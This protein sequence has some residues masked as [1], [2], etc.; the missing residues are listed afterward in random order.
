M[1]GHPDVDVPSLKVAEL[2]EELT[3]RG[4]ETKGLKKDLA[5]RLQA[6]QE[7]QHADKSTSQTETILPESTGNGYVI[8]QEAVK[9]NEGVGRTMVDGYPE[10]TSTKHHASLPTEEIKDQ[11]NTEPAALDEEVAKVVAQEESKDVL[12]PTPSPPK[13]LSPL[14]KTED[15]VGKVMVD[16]Y[17]ENELSKHHQTPSAGKDVINTEP[18]ALDKDLAKF[19]AEE[20]SKDVLTPT[21]SPPKR[22]SPLPVSE[23]EEDMQIIENEEDLIKNGESS[24]KR[25]RSRSITPS[26]SNKVKRIKFDLPERLSHIKEIPSSVLYINNLKRPLLHSTLYEYLKPCSK[27]KIDIPKNSKMPFVS[28]EYKG[29]W[30]SGVKSHAYVTYSSIEESI[31]IAEKIENKKWPEDTGDRLKIHFI[32]ENQLHELIEKEEKA[33]ENGRQKL[34]LKVYKSEEND[35]DDDN[36]QEWIYELISSGGL[37][38]ILPPPSSSSSK[39]GLPIIGR[40]IPSGPRAIPLTG[41]NSIQPSRNSHDIPLRGQGVGIRGR[42]NL[43]PN[44]QRGDRRYDKEIMKNGTGEGLRGWSDERDK[45]RKQKEVLRMRPTKYRPRLF[46]KKGP[47]AI[48]GS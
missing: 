9:D 24:K 30:L 28:S 36:N 7:S 13:S 40:E 42:A 48:E 1:S 31:K 3:K 15:G 14:P 33:W 21:P 44:L 45:E 2:K 37:G 27:P 10:N 22:L 4:L 32:P 5:D 43:Q 19:V 38:K 12:S 26:R 20:E 47:G 11:I 34:D 46:W 6:F 25:S 39:S 17:P 41:V 16:G 29:I 23:I 18:K 8:A 35:N